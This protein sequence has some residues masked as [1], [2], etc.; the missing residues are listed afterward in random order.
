MSQ[1]TQ[2]RNKIIQQLDQLPADSLPEL[3]AFIEFLQF[4]ANQNVANSKRL[5]GLWSHLPSLSE[6]DIDE[7]RHQMWQPVDKREL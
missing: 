6:L 3:Q 5:G 4:R 2:V 7:N 1:T